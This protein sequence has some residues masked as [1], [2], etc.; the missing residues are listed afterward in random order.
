MYLKDNYTGKV[1]NPLTSLEIK[2]NEDT[3]SFI[4][5]AKESSLESFSNKNND[6]LW[7]LNV[8]EVFLDMGDDFYYEFE[9]APNG[10]T[11]VAKINNGNVSFFDCDFFSSHVETSG[12]TYKVTMRFDLS[13]FKN[14]KEIR[15]NAFRVETKNV[16]D[17]QTLMALNPTFCDTFHVRDKFIIL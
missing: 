6:D 13:K 3:F 12:N 17:K 5:E 15:Y 1:G 11:F 14:T 9:V 7:R 16:G 4:F 8:T 10:K 2:R